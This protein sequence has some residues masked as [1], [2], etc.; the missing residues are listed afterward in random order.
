M[1]C[2]GERMSLCRFPPCCPYK[3]RDHSL[4][5]TQHPNTAMLGGCNRD[6]RP[7]LSVLISS[8][9]KVGTWMLWSLPNH[10]IL[11]GRTVGALRMNRYFFQMQQG[12]LCWILDHQIT[13]NKT[14]SHRDWPQGGTV[15]C[16]LTEKVL[17]LANTFTLPPKSRT[18]AN[19][20]HGKI[21]PWATLGRILL[22]ELPVKEKQP[23]DVIV[24]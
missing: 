18:T 10:S 8:A 22:Q 23:P 2:L 15:C 7:F 14:I 17:N 21:H 6:T 13:P 20:C 4:Q 5:S 12:L 11:L 24:G 16:L 9:A 3:P 1:G 19:Y